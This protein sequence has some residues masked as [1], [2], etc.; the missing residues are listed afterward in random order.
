MS[1]RKKLPAIGV[2]LLTAS[3]AVLGLAA[4]AAAAAQ[5]FE[6]A[7]AWLGAALFV[8][9]ADGPLARR[10]N[11]K[12]HLPRFCGE[13]LD[14]IVDYLNYVA[15]PAFIALRA[16]LFPEGA[17]FAGAAVILLVSLF[18][19]SDTES[20]THDGYFVGFPAIWNVVVLYLLAA[21]LPKVV[22]LAVIGALGVLTFVPVKY[23]HPVRVRSWRPLTFI[24][25]LVW[26]GAAV[27]ATV[28]GYPGGSNIQAIFF[29]SAVYFTALGLSRTFRPSTQPAE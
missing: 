20:K 7:M 16:D 22:A 5:H 9:A 2:H 6:M 13:R 21:P 4:L 15:V 1:F 27:A 17:G 18:H 12:E 28:N 3:G 29:L 8:D 26:S 23:V 25:T 24:V 10:F 14:L 19:F 11:V